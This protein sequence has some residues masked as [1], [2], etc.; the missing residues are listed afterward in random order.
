MLLKV[1]FLGVRMAMMG[2]IAWHQVHRMLPERSVAR[3]KVRD[4]RRTG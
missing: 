3:R 1:V 2:A 4:P